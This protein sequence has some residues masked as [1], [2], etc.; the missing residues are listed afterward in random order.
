MI[1]PISEIFKQLEQKPKTLF[2]VDGLG[3]M[4]T[5]FFL[6][7]ILINFNKYFGMPKT[8]L[9]YLS[10]IAAFLCIYSTICFFFLKDN[11]NFHI[12]IISIANLLYCFLTIGF[13]IFNFATLTIIGT[14]YFLVEIIVIGGLVYIKFHVAIA[15]KKNKT[16]NNKQKRT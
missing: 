16:D 4:I 8:A 7:V 3:A 5:S 11:W 1:K 12:R 2:L 9:S 10:T 14:T 15:T 13:I 6:L